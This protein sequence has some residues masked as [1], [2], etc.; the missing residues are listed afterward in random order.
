MASSAREQFEQAAMEAAHEALGPL[1][2]VEAAIG[3]IGP[4]IDPAD[5]DAQQ[6]LELARRQLRL[7]R[8]QL[9]RFGR[10]RSG[11]DEPDRSEIDLSALAREL[12]G[13]LEGTILAQHDVAVEAP[14]PVRAPV[15]VD[16][17]RALLFNLLSNAAKY[18][19]PGRM[20]VVVVDHCDD[21]GEVRVRDQGHGVAPDDAERIFER[22]ERGPVEGIEGVGLGL[23]LARETARAHGGDLVL[24]PADDD[25]GATFLLTLPLT[26]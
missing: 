21:H 8:L 20:I 15:D 24:E 9:A 2:T 12:V 10:L 14:R 13:D 26:A 25:E 11:P 7:A 19:P 4:A 6:A 22:Y 3:L 18:S 1:N 17:L 16:Q 5:E 23:P